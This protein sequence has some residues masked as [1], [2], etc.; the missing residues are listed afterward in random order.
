M[1]TSEGA[2]DYKPSSQP[3]TNQNKVC[4]QS[5]SKGALYDNRIKH[6]IT[7]QNIQNF[8]VHPGLY[9]DT[10]LP[11]KTK[12]VPITQRKKC[13]S[14]HVKPIE[15]QPLKR[16]LQEYR[17]VPK[18][19]PRHTRKRIH[20]TQTPK[21]PTTYV[22]VPKSYKSIRPSTKLPMLLRRNTFKQHQ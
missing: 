8:P 19:K 6:H 16:L 13:Q 18:E 3:P 10:I 9:A 11:A 15:N 5:T 2:R 14:T 17:V 21:I 7:Q 12:S 20:P 4:T 1:T 22:P